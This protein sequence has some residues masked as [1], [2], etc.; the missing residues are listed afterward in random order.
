MT[1]PYTAKDHLPTQLMT[2]AQVRDLDQR[3]I[4]QLQGD[5]F[6]LMRRAGE[7]AFA[8]LL[9][10]WPECESLVVLAGRGNNGGDGYVLAALAAYHGMRAQVQTLGDHDQ[11]SA[12]AQQARAMAQDAEVEILPWQPLPPQCDLVVDAL[13]GTGL[14]AD[15]SGDFAAAVAA[16]NAHAAPVLALDV[17]SG[18]NADTGR[19]MGTAVQADLTV[20]FIGIK[21]GLLTADGPDVSGD[22]AYAS[23]SVD[24]SLFEEIKPSCERISFHQLQQQGRLLAKRR[25][26]SHKGEHGHALLLGGAPGM[27]GAVALAAQA[28]YR[29]GAGLVSVATSVD[30]RAM[31]LARQPELMVQEVNSG[32]DVEPMLKRATAIGCG[33]GLGQHSWGQLLLQ[34]V[35]AASQPLVLDADALNLLAQPAWQTEFAGRQV[36]LTPHP[37][38][39]ARLLG[40]SRDQIQSQR[41]EQAQALA[42]RYKA[43]VVLKGQ[44][45]I[46]AS[47]SGQLALCSD[48]NPGMAC[49]GMGD[50]LT[51]VLTALLAQGL[52]AWQA[53][54]L[55]VCIHSAAADL[56]AQQQ[57]QRGLLAS[58]LMQS[59][60]YLVNV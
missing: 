18:L 26:N 40:V 15:V 12:S 54:C 57:G 53:A 27:G 37:G 35:L 10:R 19:I 34:P 22:I 17:A 33:P 56:Q 23:L 60:R 21:R 51:G 20:T 43:V 42:Q 7:A 36:I 24:P 55:G 16:I 48:G 50:V 29:T 1:A 8:A 2:A 25:G 47:P 46:V 31:L 9:Q 3:A 45:T 39:A 49:G 11:L 41:F 30:Q 4:A 14:S 13:L 59:I 5:G 58:D 52:D 6:E 28:C 32:L 38:E 44:G